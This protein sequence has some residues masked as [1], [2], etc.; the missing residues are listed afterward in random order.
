MTT[1]FKRGI[2]YAVEYLVVVADQPTYADE[3]IRDAGI[4]KKE[5]NEILQETQFE[6]PKLKRSL[7]VFK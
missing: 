6:V 3:L 5:A 2:W 1:D 4:T 7:K